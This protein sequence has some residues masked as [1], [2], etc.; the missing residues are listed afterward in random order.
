MIGGFSEKNDAAADKSAVAA[1]KTAMNVCVLAIRALLSAAEAE[2]CAAERASLAIFT[3]S[4]AAVADRA[5]APNAAS[6]ILLL[7]LAAS[8]ADLAIS[9]LARAVSRSC[10]AKSSERPANPTDSVAAAAACS[11]AMR[12][13]IASWKACASISWRSSRSSLRISPIARKTHSRS[14]YR[15]NKN[16]ACCPSSRRRKSSSSD[17]CAWSI[18]TPRT[19]A[20]ASLIESN[21][22]PTFKVTGNSLSSRCSRCAHVSGLRDSLFLAG[23]RSYPGSAAQ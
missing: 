4:S 3:P 2:S 15:V 7:S 22:E 23:P 20:R 11:F 21:L 6:A 18:P 17:S 9:R 8:Y 16:L 12:C 1:A 5:A 10:R 19:N 14:S 13:F